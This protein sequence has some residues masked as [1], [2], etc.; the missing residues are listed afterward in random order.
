MDRRSFLA[1]TT[2]T[3]LGV[4]L[5]AFG[6]AAQAASYPYVNRRVP[7]EATTKMG[8]LAPYG[9][10]AFAFT[11]SNGWVIVTQDGRYFARG[12]PDACFTEL[13]G[14][15]KAGRKV[16]C[17]AFPPEGGDRWVITTDK[18]MSSRGLPEECRQRIADNYAAGQPVAHVAF[19]P[20]GGNRW[21]VVTT[22]GFFARGVDDECYQMMRNLTQGGRRV[23]RVAFPYGGGWTVVAQDRF[24]ARGIDDE[25]YQQMNELAGGGWELHNVAFSPVNDGWSLCSRG[26]APV[27]PADRVRQV[28]NNVQGGTVWQRMSAW[29]TPG[30]AVAVV[31]GNRVAWSTGYGRL[32]AGGTAAVH[33]ESGFQAA[34][35]SKAV[36]AIGVMRLLQTR[37]KSLT[38][39]IR[40]Y[41]DWTL[42]RRACV[43]ES[44]VPTIDR[45]LSHRAGI[46]GRGSTSPA[47]ACSGFTA[48]GGGFAGY[49]Q[50]ATVPSLLQ[51]MNGEGNSPRIELTTTPGAEYHYSGA[52]YVLLQR[53][54]EQ[55]TG[56]T[57]DRYMTDEVFT[58]L[59]MTTS[60]YALT[61]AFELAS[62]HTTTGAV[63]PGGHN[64][65]PE[66]AAA[67]LYTNVLDLSRLICYLNK[68]WTASGDIA[69]PLS[70]SS[71][72]T[73]LSKG[74]QP[75]M[76]RGYFIAGSGTKSFSYT[77]D[78]SNH[79]FKSVFK[80]Y[81]ELGAGYAV[82]VN[83]DN[84]GL[85][86]EIAAAIR[87][88][89][90][91]A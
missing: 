68:A 15:L 47:D 38:D 67:G 52:G 12:I 41:L 21:V 23:T 42:P 82:M 83:G 58:P 25:C 66:S 9:V 80:G 5:S 87:S 33:P 44:A 24:F 54:V 34:S 84:T 31:T 10:T 72:R 27:L 17:V 48:G 1:V 60:S 71:V 77:H 36:T 59:G 76:G 70:R 81:P 4:G 8:E 35:I 49:G 2:A 56:Q 45:V 90:G 86:N 29:K 51:V 53:M 30:V 69:G 91:W 37:K 85:V 6:S 89:Y 16:T 63:I 40:P 46:I 39:D 73:M 19:P 62:G 7:A 55:E 14:L 32:T 61:P 28:E 75:D 65:Y 50:G 3:G 22:T 74:A 13:A 43:P 11:P 26:K 79:G 57:L 78:G 18:G 88:V 20:A 64:R